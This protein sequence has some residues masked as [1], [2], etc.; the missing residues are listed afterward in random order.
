[1]KLY[2][3]RRWGSGIA[4]AL[5][6]FAGRSYDFVDV[7][8]FD[9]PGPARDRLIAIKPIAQVPT[10]VLDDGTVMTE[11]AAIALW[12]A[13]ETPGLAPAPGSP[14]RARFLRLLVWLVANVYPTFTYAD[15]PERWTASAPDELVASAKAYRQTLYRWLDGEVTGPFVLGDAPC[16]VDL[17]L[18]AMV[19]WGPGRAWFEAETPRL[20]EAARR[21]RE[22]P[23]LAETMRVNGFA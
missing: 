18:A 19:N 6:A 11:T 21:T 20:A 10:L 14:E 1:M 23:Q 16:A 13:D 5:L 22:L 15:Y 8:G 17:Y 9:K 2:G 3:V 4:E 12:L 7:E